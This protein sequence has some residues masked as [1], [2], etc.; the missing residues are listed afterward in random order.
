MDQL[1]NFRHQ[2][3]RFGVGSSIDGKEIRI[4]GLQHVFSW[5][6]N[7]GPLALS[8]ENALELAA[9]IVAVSFPEEGEFERI[10]NHV[11]GK[12]VA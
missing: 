12:P 3:N 8:R 1:T 5:A 11:R 7:H 4:L 2:F 10:L 9:W 6:D